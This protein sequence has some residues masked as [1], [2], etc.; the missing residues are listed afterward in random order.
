MKT[1][2]C[3]HPSGEVFVLHQ[4]ESGVYLCPVCG[5]ESFVE[6]PYFDD[7]SASFEMCDCGFEFGFD[8]SPIASSEAVEGI[9]AN[10]IRWRRRLIDAA[11][12]SP[13]E[14][15]ALEQSLLR[16]GRRL[17]FDLIDVATEKTE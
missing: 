9:E 13:T 3:H 6:P 16:I 15:A 5:S 1:H 12:R 4:A 17:A 2:S 11:T 14:F 8:D 10:W 7:G